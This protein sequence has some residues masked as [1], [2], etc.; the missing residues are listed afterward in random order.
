MKKRDENLR[1]CFFLKKTMGN[2]GDEKND[3]SFGSAASLKK[4]VLCRFLMLPF[5]F[6]DKWVWNKWFT[7]VF[8]ESL[9]KK[10]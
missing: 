4:S 10:G 9:E 1:R 8:W 6:W 5:K 7:D 2:N 3:G